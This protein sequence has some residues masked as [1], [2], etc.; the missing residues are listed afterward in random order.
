MRIATAL[1]CLAGRDG[2]TA[3]EFALVAPLFLMFVFGSVEFGRLLWTREALQQS[4]IAGA[5]CMA[6]AQGAVQSSPCSASGSYSAATTKT[7]IQTVANG[8]GVSLPVSAI[9]VDN[10]ATCASTAGFSEVTIAYTFTSVAPQV[11][12]L[13]AGGSTLTLTACSPNNAY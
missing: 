2:T 7:Y 5:R 12:L 8:W 3:V 11:V 13:P 10:N 4:A 6:L 1:A 9:T